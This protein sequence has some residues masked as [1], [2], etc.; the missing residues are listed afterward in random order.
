MV[1]RCGKRL[2][3]RLTEWM[4]KMEERKIM[5]INKIEYLKN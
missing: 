1:G 5:M 4:E 2:S 3:Q